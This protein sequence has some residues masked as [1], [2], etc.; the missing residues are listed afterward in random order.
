MQWPASERKPCE[1]RSSKSKGT[2]HPPS[3]FPPTHPPTHPPS[4]FPPTHPPTHPKREAEREAEIEEAKK[5]IV[6]PRAVEMAQLSSILSPLGLKI[7]E[8]A[9]DGH[10]LYRAVAHQVTLPPSHPPTHPIVYLP[11][12]LPTYLPMQSSIDSPTHL[13][14]YYSSSSKAIHPPTTKPSE[15]EPLNI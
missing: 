8:V 13:P 3:P 10:C 11:T 6:P 2:S 12:Y 1:R 9:A 14:P 7:E 15:R 4:P 5:H